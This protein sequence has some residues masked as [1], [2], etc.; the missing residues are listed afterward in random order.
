MSFPIASL[1]LLATIISAL[2]LFILSMAYFF[3]SSSFSAVSAAKDTIK[4][5]S[6]FLSLVRARISSFSISSILFIFCFFTFLSNVFAGLKSK[7]AA[8]INNISVFFNSL[9]TVSFNS[10]VVST[11]I[12]LFL[13]LVIK[14][15]DTLPSI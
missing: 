6:D 14:G 3:N 12:F 10:S 9:K 2:F 15:F 5:F 13:E 4:V 7:G 8:A 11:F 1:I